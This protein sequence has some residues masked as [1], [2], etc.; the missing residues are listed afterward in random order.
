MKEKNKALIL[1]FLLLVAMLTCIATIGILKNKQIKIVAKSKPIIKIDN[2]KFKDLNN[3]GKLDKYEDWRL[4]SDQRAEDL[5][6]QMTLE[7]KAGMMVINSGYY[8]RKNTDDDSKL[9]ES[10][11]SNDD[12]V[13]LNYLGNTETVVDLNIRHI[14]TRE[15]NLEPEIIAQWNNNLNELA[16]TTR[17]GIPVMLASNSKNNM[18]YINWVD[19]KDYPYTMYPSELGVAAA[20]MGE[21]EIKRKI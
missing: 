19:Y 15:D 1:I 21:K 5:V 13:Y 11:S 4:S 20:F 17:L 9:N 2:L 16:E 3:N 10:I 6:R 14:I 18:S 7:E 8:K 12:R